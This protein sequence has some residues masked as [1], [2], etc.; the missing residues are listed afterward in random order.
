[1]NG[2]P[3]L[4]LHAQDWLQLLGHYLMLSLLSVGGAVSAVPDMHRFLV[5]Q[6]HWLTDAQFNA[7]IALA[8][9]SPGPNLLFVAVLGWNVGLNAG[10]WPTGLLGVALSLLGILL[11]STALTYSAAQWGQRN[12]ELRAVRAFK[13]GLA[14][15]VVALLM[16]TSW[17]MASA[18]GSSLANWPLWLLTGTTAVI[19]WRSQIHLLWLLAAGALLGGLG[20]V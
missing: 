18:N 13:Q 3:T 16:A 6:Q 14:P 7:S 8:Q 9:A 20:V 5:E 10:G 11:P 4:A 15:I 2:A 19:V 1:M 17:I 12:R